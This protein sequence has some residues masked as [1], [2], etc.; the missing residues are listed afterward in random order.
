VT[1][2]SPALRAGS[3]DPALLAVAVVCLVAAVVLA[4]L[5]LAYAGV[6]RAVL[7]VPLALAIAVGLIWLLDRRRGGLSA[8]LDG[9]A[10]TPTRWWA[11]A[12]LLASAS[13][14]V[15]GRLAA[16][17]GIVDRDPGVYAM[18]ARWLVVHHD[19]TMPPLVGP[20]A[21]QLSAGLTP[22]ADGQLQ[23]QFV[24]GLPV[25]EAVG[26]WVLG[27]V[28]LYRMPAALAALAL[29]AVFGLALEL[30]RPAWAFTATVLLAISLPF[31]YVA[32]DGFSEPLMLIVLATGAWMLLS[33]LRV[34][35][36]RR[37]ALAGVLIGTAACARV[38]FMV[39]G[40]ALALVVVWVGTLAGNREPGSSWRAGART[41][42][43]AGLVPGVAVGLLDVLGR[44]HAYFEAQHKPILQI[45][46]VTAAVVLAGV[47]LGRPP[48]VARRTR[49]I[50]ERHRTRLAVGAVAL[51]VLA[52]G[53]AAALPLLRTARDPAL[54]LPRAGVFVPLQQ[55]DGVHPIDP[56]RTFY[57]YAGHWI[58]W[59]DGWPVLILALAGAALLLWRVAR[60]EARVAEG[61]VLA[62]AVV[63][64]TL[65]V[66][67]P[68]I[69]PDQ[70][71]AA[72]RMVPF[73][74]P[75]ALLLATATVA[76]AVERARSYG[77]LAARAVLAI[78][79]VALLVPAALTTG[80]VA[81]FQQ[82]A[83]L[84]RTIDA[85][86]SAA[87]ADAALLV[88]PETNL[89]IVLPGVLTTWCGVP[90]SGTPA[91]TNVRALTAAWR[92]RGR[93]LWAV[94]GTDAVLRQYGF[95]PVARGRT[96]MRH[97]LRPTVLGAPDR[98]EAQIYELVVGRPP[99]R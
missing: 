42:L 75:G 50:W 6:F 28:G 13:G 67:K 9:A 74:L 16:E 73:A 66:A 45:V 46:E 47:A 81:R 1:A 41:A 40:L 95:T 37:A 69:Y 99:R 7:L 43:V 35:S 60:G 34:S 98:T 31:V 87:P 18:T 52:A 55:Q 57:E 22:G 86:C 58:A 96:V 78:G 36:R 51:L 72:R 44:S 71:W 17:H 10:P 5:P 82:S 3:R 54:M 49:A 29:L 88:L 20:F 48:A 94:A 85:A 83:G 27:E 33:A 68:S 4:G 2:P 32:R 90:A 91:G 24:H 19:L 56:T 80:R 12:Y 92:A 11:G 39:Y 97:V 23:F 61:V 8:T 14:L 25:L 79:L 76:L 62:F 65:I 70:P 89:P 26:D 64:L 77:L 30:L 63:P 15:N 21:G 38:D 53:L 84:Q 93:E 59:H